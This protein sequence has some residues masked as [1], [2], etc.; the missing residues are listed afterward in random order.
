MESIRQLS[1]RLNWRYVFVGVV[2]WWLVM[3]IV[4]SLISLRV[5]HLKKRL[6]KTGVELTT[7]L[8]HRVSLPLLEKDSQSIHRLLT[9]AAGKP[10]VFYASVV[11][12]RNKVVA[13]TGTGHLMP[14]MTPTARGIETVTI[15]EGGF[16]S[17]AKIVNF[18]S[19]ITYA[20][21]KIGE[22]FIGMSTPGAVETR[23][24][25]AII[26]VI[27]GILLLILVIL[28][29]YQSI[30][31]TLTKTF[32]VSASTAKI[33]TDARGAQIACPLCGTRKPLS[34]TLFKQS[35]LDAHLTGGLAAQ[36]VN[37]N[38]GVANSDK[39]A[40]THSVTDDLL[41]LKRRIVLR[42]ADIIKKLT[43]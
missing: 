40:Q 26:A 36:N 27:S 35:N 18:V 3:L 39:D 9:E 29:R 17:H 8:G 6:S 33:E 28:I 5:N 30:K 21:T 38:P 34:A 20:G 13:F 31:E 22:L 15:R 14:D 42:C 10:G 1:S 4:Y 7:E 25:F 23:K 2:V 32:P 43:A 41:W 37:M 11:D 12:H 16:A 19:D 24:I